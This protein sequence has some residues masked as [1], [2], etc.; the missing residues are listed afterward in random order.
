MNA[1]EAS[2]RGGGSGKLK[3]KSFPVKLHELLEEAEAR[4]LDHIISWMPHGRA[5]RVHDQKLFIKE[6]VFP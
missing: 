2:G 4:E 1:K 5:F 3:P 6:V